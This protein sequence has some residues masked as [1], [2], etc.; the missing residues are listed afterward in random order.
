MRGVLLALLL[1]L[2]PAAPAAAQEP[3]A[4]DVVY[5]VRKGDSLYSL[6]ERHFRRPGDWRIAQRLNRVRD[7]YRMPVGRTLRIPRSLLKSEPV[8]ARIISFR[9]DA[10][11][12]RRG[13]DE[14]IAPGAAVLQGDEIVTGANSFVSV[15]MPD[16][17]AVALPSQSH[18]TVRRLRRITLTGAVE[19]WFAVESGRA[20]AVV[21]PLGKEDAFHVSTPI[22][23][24]A[25]RGTEFRVKY[26]AAAGRA[27]TETLAG[28][29]VMT[30]GDETARLEAG[31]GA[32]ASGA[33]LTD[34][35]ALL[36]APRL[37]D[38]GQ[39]QDESDLVFVIEPLAGAAEYRAQ[40]AQDAGFLD[41]AAEAIAQEP[42]VRLVAVPDGTW[43]VRISA[44]DENGLE[45]RY[46]TYS[47][48][49]RL[50]RIEATVDATQAGR[51]RQYLFRWEVQGEGERQYRF[52]LARDDAFEDLLVDEP[53]L[54]AKR[55]ILTD[56]PV[57]TFYWRVETLQFVDGQVHGKWSPAERLTI[58]S[59]E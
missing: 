48:Q 5:Q 43:F 56:L 55:F 47:F 20:R 7:P 37:A 11:L 15:G 25:V 26:D 32:T 41:V 30:R 58:S 59:A 2:L 39:V 54:S 27:S 36:P 10:R 34:P 40:V 57:G 53:G 28:E 23:V 31:F 51:Y 38:P 9:G 45:G 16:D 14:A 22:A 35:V 1:L 49:R 24:S 29:V 42:G 50:N 8:A 19:R 33:E 18:V 3:S 21:S 17:S 6:A 4:P 13:Q 52:Q 12:R 46:E 44:I